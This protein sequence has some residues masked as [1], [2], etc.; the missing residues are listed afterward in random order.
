MEQETL[1]QKTV[2]MAVRGRRLLPNGAGRRPAL[3]VACGVATVA[4]W[5]LVR[6]TP[7]PGTDGPLW[8][9]P[10]SAKAV[11]LVGWVGILFALWRA[12]GWM[13]RDARNTY[14]S[15][16]GVRSSATGVCWYRF[17]N[18][19]GPV[20]N[21]YLHRDLL[22]QFTRREVEGRYRGSAL[23]IIWSLL[24]PLLML[25]IYSVVF[26]VILKARWRQGAE[27]S[28]GE[29][30]ITL[31][32]GLIAFNVFAECLT[33]APVLVVSNPNYVKKVVFPLEILPVS[34]LWAA[35]FHAAV[36]VVLL[37]AGKLLLTGSLSATLFLVPVAALPLIGLSL[38]VS[39]FL[40]SLGVYLRDVSHAV[41]IVIQVLFFLTP[42]FYPIDVV[43][44]G[45]QTV[46]RLNPLFEVVESFRRLLVWQQPLDWG[47]WLAVTALSGVVL[48][49]GYAWFMKTKAGF[50]DVI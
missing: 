47:A 1:I 29:F 24:T 49:L 17:L 35:L 37:I 20:Y 42:I 14:V 32:A 5:L 43:P 31:F 2:A 18:P 15:G 19:V 21:L 38:G 45:L 11:L 23:G 27:V 48:L 44:P 50:A 4:L 7:M 36:S 30:T 13:V 33:R 26:S 39:W 9:L 46:L 25:V 40:A 16:L 41:G 34:A 3:V 12:V 22:R 10:M 28:Q 8:G 6:E